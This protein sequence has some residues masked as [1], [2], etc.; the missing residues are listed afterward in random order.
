MNNEK[1]ETTFR[2][3]LRGIGIAILAAGTG[4][5]IYDHRKQIGSACKSISKKVFKKTTTVSNESAKP[6]TGNYNNP[7]RMNYNIRKN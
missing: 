5:A 7:K 3:V 4:L 2:K 6:N 1:K